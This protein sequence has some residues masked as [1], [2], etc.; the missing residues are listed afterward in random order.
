MNGVIETAIELHR[1]LRGRGLDLNPKNGRDVALQANLATRLG[2]SSDTFTSDLKAANVSAEVYLRELMTVAQPFAQM[3]EEIWRYLGRQCAPK[4]TESLRIRFG[5]DNDKAE[6]DWDQFR[7]MVQTTRRVWKSGPVLLW[8][9][10]DLFSLARILTQALPER[11]HPRYRPGE[12]LHLHAVAVVVPEDDLGQRVRQVLQ[13]L[14]DGIHALWP[15]EEDARR[16]LPELRRT[17]L[18]EAEEEE[19]SRMRSLA[20]LLTDLIPSWGD[21]FEQWS[22]LPRRAKVEANNYFN[23]HVLPKLSPGVSSGWRT[24]L[25]ALDV[26]DLPF[27]RYRWHTYEVWAVVKALEALEGFRPRPIVKAGHIALDASEPSLVAI[28]SARKSIFAY[29]QGETLLPAPIGKRKK[30]RPDLRFSIDDPPTNAGTVAIIEFKQRRNLDSKHASEVLTAYSAGVSLGG[31]VIMINYDAV[32]S[33]PIP[34][35]CQLLGNVHPGEP[36]Q[37]ECYQQSVRECFQ[38]ASLEPV[39]QNVIV[40][41]DIS[42]SMGTQYNTSEAQR[43]LRQLLAITGLRIFRFNNGLVPGGDWKG[44]QGLVVT[45][46]T[47]LGRALR[48]L[49]EDPSVGVP[50]RLLVITDGGHDHPNDLLERVPDHRESEPSDLEET[51][52]WLRG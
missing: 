43:G 25:E 48:Q 28:L 23:S 46:G 24:V 44:S 11:R 40:L 7:L 41:L 27:W 36:I 12:A 14:I 45:G 32:P 5:F 26:L 42:S 31:G 50:D 13:S 17:D 22:N 52:D 19:Q 39:C 15:K 37:V 34:P 29:A 35:M 3:F 49:F 6:I 8:Q 20:C 51:I 21:I 9:S 47:E 16:E 4:A 1:E 30:I 10:E 38:R 2:V 18:E 33:M